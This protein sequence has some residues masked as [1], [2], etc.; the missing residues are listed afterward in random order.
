MPLMDVFKLPCNLKKW[1]DDMYTHEKKILFSDIDMSAKMSVSGILNALQD[2]VNINSESIGRGIKYMKE[3]ARAWFAISWNIEIKRYPEMFE[4][5]VVK[6]W[7]YAFSAS[8]GYRN[9][10][11]TDSDGNDIICADSIWTLVDTNTGRPVKITDEDRKGYDTETEYPIEKSG[12]KIKLPKDIPHAGEVKVCRADIDFN[13]H[14]SNARYIQMA[15]EYVP[16]DA[17][18]TRI[19]VEYKKQSKYGEK[20]SVGCIYEDAECGGHYILT[21]TGEEGQVRAIVEFTVNNG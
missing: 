4:D 3:T 18:I 5:V 11:I 10:I 17:D 20:L 12:R 21:F 16:F 8:M 9:V 6:T 13:G 2:C 1:E 7:P 14:M 19:R 15:M